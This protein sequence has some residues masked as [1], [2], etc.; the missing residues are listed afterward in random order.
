[1]NRILPW[2]TYPAPWDLSIASLVVDGV[3]VVDDHVNPAR[4]LVTMPDEWD[5]AVV[6]IHATTIQQ[7]AGTPVGAVVCLNSPRTLFRLSETADG[8]G[9]YTWALPVFHDDV[10]GAVDLDVEV[11]AVVGDRVR[12]V[13]RTEPWRIIVDAGRRPTPPGMP[14]VDFEWVDFTGPSAPALAQAN[15]RQHVVVDVDGDEPRVYLNESI[16]GLQSILYSTSA[17]MERRLYRNAIAAEVAAAITAAL[18][19]QAFTLVDPENPDESALPTVYASALAGVADALPT[20]VASLV[21]SYGQAEQ[22][23]LLAGFWARVDIAIDQITG[24]ADAITDMAKEAL[25]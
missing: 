6:T 17:R 21:H 15:P 10:G 9:A 4:N 5:E 2:A 16:E 18:V 8:P 11:I 23:G 13:G 24:R 25:R 20:D 12:T 22:D 7:F 3:D 14:P 1:M 19:R